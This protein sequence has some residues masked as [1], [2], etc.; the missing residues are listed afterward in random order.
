MPAGAA[1]AAAA[2]EAAQGALEKLG[3][4]TFFALLVVLGTLAL[5]DAAGATI[6][7]SAYFFAALVTIALGLVL[8]AWVGRARG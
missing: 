2:A 7:V 5:I 4:I 1:Q 6:A 8:G 3:R